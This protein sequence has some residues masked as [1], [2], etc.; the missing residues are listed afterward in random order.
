[1]SAVAA[2]LALAAV[3]AA[4]AQLDDTLRD[5]ADSGV[6]ATGSSA[7]AAEQHD[8]GRLLTPTADTVFADAITEL[9]DASRTVLELTPSDAETADRR[10]AVEEALREALDAVTGA[11]AA[12]ARGD[13]L[14]GWGERLERARDALEAVS[15]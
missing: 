10:D 5:A 9:T 12:L 2:A 15:P 13:A 8:A 4:C 14:D 3:L 1:M 11:R 6:A 7:I